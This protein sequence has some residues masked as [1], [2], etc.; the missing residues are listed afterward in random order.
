MCTLVGVVVLVVAAIIVFFWPSP[1]DDIPIDYSIDG[2]HPV[3]RA[4]EIL[5]QRKYGRWQ[6][7]PITVN[8]TPGEYYEVDVRAEWILRNPGENVTVHIEGDHRE[9]LSKGYSK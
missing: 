5:E 4:A 2:V 3:I 9:S 1:P 7:P 6:G 8:W